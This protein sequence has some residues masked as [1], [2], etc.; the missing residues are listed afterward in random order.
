MT[1]TGICI[2]RASTVRYT[3]GDILCREM[4]ELTGISTTLPMPVEKF[5]D[6]KTVIVDVFMPQA[7]NSWI[8]FT[9]EEFDEYFIVVS[10]W[11]PR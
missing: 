8:S 5:I 4:V 3:T 9:G 2:A 7:G 1:Y 11:Q 6:G 10:G